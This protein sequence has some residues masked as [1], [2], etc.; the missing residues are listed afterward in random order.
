MLESAYD[1]WASDTQAG[2][3]SLLVAASTRDVT[4]LNTR[5][6]L[7]RIAAGAVEGAGVALRD[8]TRAG[9]GDRI[10]TRRND[11]RLT[12]NHQ[13]SGFVKNGDTWTVIRQHHN[14]GLVVARALPFGASR[15]RA[16]IRLPADYVAH[17]V[18]LAYATTTARAQG[19]TVD[20]T[21]VLVDD[22]LTRESLY[23]AVTRGRDN[24]CL[25]VQTEPLL[26]VNAE[27]PPHSTTEPADVLRA[28]LHR[29]SAKISATQ[30]QRE[31]PRQRAAPRTPRQHTSVP[32]QAPASL[33]RRVTHGRGATAGNLVLIRE[34]TSSAHA[35]GS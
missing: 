3:T 2:P 29:R 27:R 12:D 7:E 30:V 23:V 16:G 35:C 9:V 31:D 32:P 25:Y 4:A 22:T 28:V 33:A 13:G 5:A 20:T 21:H 6:R 24:T 1:A 8:G 14:G 26:D 10:V 19:R 18:E 17:H 34:A 11:R 15:R